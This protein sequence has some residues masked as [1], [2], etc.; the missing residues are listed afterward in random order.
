MILLHTLMASACLAKHRKLLAE[1]SLMKAILRHIVLP[2]MSWFFL[3]LIGIATAREYPARFSAF[4]LCLIV[5]GLI[6]ERLIR[7]RNERRGWRVGSSGRDTMFYD[8]KVDG[9]WKRITIYAEM[10]VGKVDRLIYLS[11][12]EFPEWAKSREDEIIAR[13]KSEYPPPQYEYE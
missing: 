5:I 1:P 7:A 9:E 10:L 12:I 8:E 11:S 2:L 3:I 4:I 6:R 13:I